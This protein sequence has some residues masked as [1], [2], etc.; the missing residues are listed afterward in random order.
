MTHENGFLII[1]VKRGTFDFLI[2]GSLNE[3]EWAKLLLQVM[4]RL[5]TAAKDK[6]KDMPINMGTF[7]PDSMD[8]RLKK[9]MR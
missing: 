3:L 5:K 6:P 4:Q 8:E 2:D 9:S 7:K 1:H